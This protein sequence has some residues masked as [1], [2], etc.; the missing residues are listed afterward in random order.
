MT[1]QEVF[2]NSHLLLPKAH[3]GKTNFRSF[4]KELSKG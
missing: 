2:N 1:L 3:V 4:V